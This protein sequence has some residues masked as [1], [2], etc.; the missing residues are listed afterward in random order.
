MKTETAIKPLEC[1]NLME[2]PNGGVPKNKDMKLQ[3]AKFSAKEAYK[4]LGTGINE[5]ID[6]FV[7]QLE[8][9]QLASGFCWGGVFAGV[10]VHEFRQIKCKT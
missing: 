7:R 3:L 2:T 1:M 10:K 4:G 5:W 6:R 9:A 8:R